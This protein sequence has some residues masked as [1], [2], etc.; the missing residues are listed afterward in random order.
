MGVFVAG[1]P[2]AEFLRFLGLATV[3]NA[4]G[5]IVFVGLVKYGHISA[6]E[7]RSPGHR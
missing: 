2:F 6:S 3:G 1:V 4:V 5:G 7:T